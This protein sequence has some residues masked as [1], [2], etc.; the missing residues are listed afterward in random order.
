VNKNYKLL[1]YFLGK[2]L[3]SLLF[4]LAQVESNLVLAKFGF[5]TTTHPPQSLVQFQ[6][7]SEVEIR[8]IGLL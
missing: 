8:D 3:L 1:I 5:I 6:G 7:T 2:L 4:G